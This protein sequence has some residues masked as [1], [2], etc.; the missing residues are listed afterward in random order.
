M[1]RPLDEGVKIKVS[2]RRRVDVLLL[3]MSPIYHFLGDPITSGRLRQFT[4]GFNKE[5]ND[6]E[7]FPNLQELVVDGVLSVTCLPSFINGV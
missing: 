3:Q 2:W 5:R 6:V 7:H 1:D 4:P